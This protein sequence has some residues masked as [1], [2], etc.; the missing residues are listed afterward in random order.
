MI[1]KRLTIAAILAL[2]LSGCGTS[3]SPRFYSLSSTSNPGPSSSSQLAI[4]V[5]PVAIPA[6]VD[7]PQF[8]VQNGANQV[9]IEEF[10][11]WSAPLSDGIAR[12]VAGD[13]SA[14]L[15]TPDVAVAPLANFKASYRVTNDVQRFDSMP[16]KAAV[17]EAVWVVQSVKGGTQ[18]GRTSAR[19]S[20]QNDSFD[21]LAAAHSRALSK[22]SDDIAAA[23]RQQEERTPST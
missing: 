3:A 1:H 22:L 13:L 11:R 10:N 15:G 21:S 8:V 17:L 4:L 7:R 20:V 23:I 2:L 6:A 19:E 9:D 5:G 12:T 14:S 16:G 18:S